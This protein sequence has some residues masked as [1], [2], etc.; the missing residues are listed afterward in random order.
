MVNSTESKNSYNF[1]E[2][3]D[4]HGTGSVKWDTLKDR[5]GTDDLLPL[6]IADMD[7]RSPQPIIDA[8]VSKVKQGVYGYSYLTQSYYD[9]V[10]GWYDRRYSW[11]IKSEWIVFTP[12]VIPAVSFAVQ[13][14]TNP[15]DKVI[16]QTPVYYPFFKAIES[17]GRHVLYNPLR[18][19]NDHYE[20]DFT[21]LKEK[22][23]DPRAKM[24]ILCSPHNPVGRVWTRDELQQLG[25]I[26]VDNGIMIVADEIHSDLMYPGVKFTNFAS[27]SQKFEQN[28]ITCTSATK[29][30]NLAG[31]QGSNII[32]PNKRIRQTFEN[33]VASAGTHNPNSFVSDAF[34]AGYDRCD[35]WLDQLMLYISGNLHFL[36]EFLKE[37]MPEVKVIEP[38][39]TYLCWLDFREIESDPATLE[40]L[41]I[42]DAKIALDE[43]YIFGPEG[44]GF[45]RINLAC[46]RSILERALT[47]I[48]NALRNHTMSSSRRSPKETR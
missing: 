6:W 46:P 20:M 21:D 27:I 22:V 47:Q 32:I 29:T 39:G 13:G 8:L 45:E 1:D 31:L 43:G 5:Y 18:L 48:A 23:L 41:M 15:G 24:I 11:K 26:C 17:N 44:E 37:N 10:I 4:R 34:Q 3:I 35:D 28:S 7:F 38:E 40:K 9:S 19:K 30:F 42:K 2:V 12:G 25:D 36:K 16:V 14:F 33:T